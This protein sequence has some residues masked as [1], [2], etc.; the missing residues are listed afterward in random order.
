MSKDK[1]GDL[2][3][4]TPRAENYSDWY[5]DVIREGKL[6]EVAHV[7]KGCMV[8]K[9][10][11]YAIWEKIQADLDRR[12]KE[13][14]HVNA[15]FP[16]LIPE[17]FIK[18]EAEH[19]E[20]FSPEL[21]VVTIAGGEKLEEPYIIRPTSETIIGHF[22]SQWIQS[23]RDLPMLM[24]QWANVMRWELRTRMFLRTSEFLWQEGHTAHA[25]HE[26]ALEEVH[27]MLRVYRDFAWD[28]MAMPVIMGE[29]TESEKFAGAVSSFCIEAMMQ[30]GKALQ[31]GTSHDLGQNFGK[32][33]DVKFQ[34]KEGEHTYVWQT[35]WGVSTRLIGGLVMTHSDDD[36][37]ILPPKLAPLQVAIVPFF[38]K[39]AEENQRVL[40]KGREMAAE[41]KAAGISVKFDEREGQPGPKFYEYER[42]GVP[43]RF[44][45]GP[46]DLENGV[47]E[48]KRRDQKDKRSVPLG[49]LAAFAKDELDRMQTDLL[50]VAVAR[51]EANTVKADSYDALK[52]IMAADVG[53]FVLGHWDGTKETEAK[54]KAE[55]GATIRCIP[56]PDQ[57]FE[58]EPGQCI[59]T[60]RPSKRRVIW[61][62][63]Y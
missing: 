12:F 3:R 23:W 45:I 44:G 61:A 8:I 21:A 36:G 31:A 9:P 53:K 6:A 22:F 42:M 33:F 51:R 35:S 34:S 27:R 40:E 63:A 18:R 4:I 10:H 38:R 16:L 52:E 55:I 43:L 54:V 19:V 26:E 49:G 62:K 50:N 2:S 32:A 46:K 14:G 15:Y 24:N 48:L 7:V 28:M 29:K 11:G 47:T 59:V 30:D 60:G 1:G 58:V 17:S 39:S 37:L 41:L 5:Q 20:G 57:G 56:L 13:T 25:T